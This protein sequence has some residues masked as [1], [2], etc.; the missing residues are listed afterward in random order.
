LC[1]LQGVVCQY[2]AVLPDA[3]EPYYH[4]ERMVGWALVE[5]EDADSERQTR[6][7]GLGPFSPRFGL[8]TTPKSSSCKSTRPDKKTEVKRW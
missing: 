4:L 2:Y 8:P 5:F 1:P 3:E 7:V 6:I